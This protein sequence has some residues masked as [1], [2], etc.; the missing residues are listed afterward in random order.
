MVYAIPGAVT[1][2]LSRG[3]HKLIYDGAGIAYC[4]E[5][6]LEELG[7]SMERV[8]QNGEKN[9]LGLARDLNMVYS[10]LDLRP[11]NPDYIVRKTGFSPAQVSNCLVELTLRGL[12][13]ESGRHYY[14]KD[15]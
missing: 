5:I 8:T 3:C 10:C 1:D 6:M 15:S 11:K 2:E 9:N 4:P 13:R 12:I 14:V 7:I